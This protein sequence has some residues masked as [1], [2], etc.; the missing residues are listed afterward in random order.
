MLSEILLHLVCTSK[1]FCTWMDV[2]ACSYMENVCFT[3]GQ[4]FPPSRLGFAVH[5]VTDLG[6]QLNPSAPRSKSPKYSVSA[7]QWLAN[8]FWDCVGNRDGFDFGSLGKFNWWDS[9]A[10]GLLHWNEFDK[11]NSLIL[12]LDLWSVLTIQGHFIQRCFGEDPL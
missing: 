3:Q 10:N 7:A 4:A 12:D 9:W 6:G 8:F 1:N 5:A 11:K 2:C